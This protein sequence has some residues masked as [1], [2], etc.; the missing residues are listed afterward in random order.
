MSIRRE[1]ELK[2]SAFYN[3]LKNFL[4]YN[5]GYKIG[6]VARWGSRTTGEHRDKSDLDVIFWIVRNPSK[7]KIYLALINKLKK[8]LKV[9]TDIGSSSNVIKIW[10]EGVTCDLVLLS[11]SDYRTQINTRR[12][13]E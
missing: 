12:F 2:Y 8:T 7:Q 5:S 13:I 3:S 6:G 4:N 9:N 11:E 10:K 1:A